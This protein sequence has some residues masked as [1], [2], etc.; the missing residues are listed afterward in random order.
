MAQLCLGLS[1]LIWVE[2]IGFCRPNNGRQENV[3]IV[4]VGLLC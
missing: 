3:P 4:S 2:M 1:V